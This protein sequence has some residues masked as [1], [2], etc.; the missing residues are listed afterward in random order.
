MQGRPRLLWFWGESGS[1]S[2]RAVVEGAFFRRGSAEAGGGR[3][4]VL[5]I[6]PICCSVQGLRFRVL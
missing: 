1:G 4:V 3:E 5:L 2:L 6:F